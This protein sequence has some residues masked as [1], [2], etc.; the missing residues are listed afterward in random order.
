MDN[1]NNLYIGIGL[2]GQG[3]AVDVSVRPRLLVIMADT[4][5]PACVTNY[6]IMFVSRS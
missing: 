4:L 2:R 6:F 1:I 5:T 3:V